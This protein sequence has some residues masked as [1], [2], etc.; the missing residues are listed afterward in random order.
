MDKIDLK[1]RLRQLY[2]PSARDPAMVDVPPMNYLM[3]DGAGDPNTAPAY[4]A[5]VEALFSTAYAIKFAMKKGLQAIDYTVMPLEGLWWAEDMSSFTSGERTA[6]KWTMMILQPDIV[7]A[8]I[9]QSTIAAVRVKKKLP[10]LDRI[11][12]ESFAEGACAQVLHVGPFKDEGPT[13]A[14]LHAFI[15]ES[16]YALRGKHHEI[17]LSDVRRADPK[18][19]RT[20]IRQP[21][22]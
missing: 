11:R 2:R 13:I 8:E 10:A 12:F 21:C 3:I 22:G 6:W 5:A 1:K 20:V 15:T 16:G 4:A 7:T 17:Y 18:G 9:V 14:R 19:W